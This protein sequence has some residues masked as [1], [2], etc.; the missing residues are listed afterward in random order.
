M[1]TKNQVD[2]VEETHS[3]WAR[4]WKQLMS[5]ITDNLYNLHPPC[6]AF[7]FIVQNNDKYFEHRDHE[8]Q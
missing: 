4:R 7:P 2:T 5:I 8:S 1:K 6:N 3:E